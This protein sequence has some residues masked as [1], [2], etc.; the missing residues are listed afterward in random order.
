MGKQQRQDSDIATLD[1]IT[2]FDDIT[3]LDNI[4]KLSECYGQY[5][6]PSQGK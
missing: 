6:R 1:D 5:P 4:S 2:P 3:T